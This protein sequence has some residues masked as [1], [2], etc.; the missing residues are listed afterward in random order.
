MNLIDAKIFEPGNENLLLAAMRSRLSAGALGAVYEQ[1]SLDVGHYLPPK[2]DGME[3]DLPD[4]VKETVGESAALRTALEQTLRALVEKKLE[5]EEGLTDEEK[6]EQEE[7]IA[8]FNAFID[9]IQTV[10]MS[11]GLGKAFLE[12]ADS[13]RARLR[14]AVNALDTIT[15]SKSAKKAARLAHLALKVAKNA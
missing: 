7:F 9:Q 8:M 6:E 2:P 15:R 14:I 1:L 11:E 10:L 3:Q 4:M 5:H 13:V 12:E